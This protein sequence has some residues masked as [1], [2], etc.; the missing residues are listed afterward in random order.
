MDVNIYEVTKSD[1]L[2]FGNQLG[3]STTLTALGGVRSAGA[4]FNGLSQIIEAGKTA[5]ALP[6]SFGAALILPAS[7]LAALQ[8]KNRT[9][10]IASTQVH[11]FN[12]E[13]SSARIGQRVP[14]QTAQTYPFGVQTG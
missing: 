2:Q 7:Q 1:L 13:E 9:K 12:G 11:A 4:T 10:L 6:S 5:V 3:D 14:V 8:S